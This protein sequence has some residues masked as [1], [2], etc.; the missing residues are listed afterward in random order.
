MIK[1]TRLEKVL[2]TNRPGIINH[3]DLWVIGNVKSLTE[4]EPGQLGCIIS[5]GTNTPEC[6][7]ELTS[8]GLTPNAIVRIVDNSNTHLVFY[9]GDKKYVAD[10]ACLSNIMAK[11]LL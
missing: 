9:I 2:N 6:L 8:A 4:F 3:P 11:L 1:N 5:I 10:K 7:K